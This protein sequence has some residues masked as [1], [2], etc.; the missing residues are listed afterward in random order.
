M[1][2]LAAIPF[3][4]ILIGIGL[5]YVGVLPA[6]VGWGLCALGVLIGLG[7]AITIFFSRIFKEQTHFWVFAII[8]ALPF[9]VAVPMVI[10]DLSYPPI[11][12]VSTDIVNPPAFVAALRAPPNIGRDMAFPERFGQIVKEAYPT[13]RPLVLD[14]SPDL[15]FQRVEKLARIQSGW[16]VK[17]R[18]AKMRILEGEVVTSFFRFV[19]DFIIRVSDHAG[20][21][22]VDMR[23]KSRDGL[24]DA[25]A[26]AKRIQNFLVQLAKQHT[27]R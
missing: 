16:V 25:G 4:M 14:E 6:M 18:N 20:K 1:K 8:A 19:D 24:V 5:S 3:L 22:H 10:N 27:D 12:D 2:F 23:S 13:I 15:V 9:V 26:N 21:T 11:N 17:H 7:V